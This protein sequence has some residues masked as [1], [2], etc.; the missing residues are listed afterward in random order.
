MVPFE[1]LGTVSYSDSIV[2][3][4]LSCTISEIKRDIG[5]KSR[6]SYPTCIRIPRLWESPQE[7]CHKLGT[8]ILECRMAWL[9]EG[10]NSLTSLA[11]SIA[12]FDS[13]CVTVHYSDGSHSEDHGY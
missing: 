2:T 10:Q 9:P 7:Y 12:A 8:E 5:P 4:A 6:F 3:M 1:S 11:V 13:C